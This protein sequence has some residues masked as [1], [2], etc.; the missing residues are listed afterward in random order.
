MRRGVGLIV[1]GPGWGVAP[2]DEGADELHEWDVFVRCVGQN[3]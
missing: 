3:M 1:D 2:R